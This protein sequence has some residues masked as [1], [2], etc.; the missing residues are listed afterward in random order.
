MNE[1][2][3]APESP[4][5]A[6]RAGLAM[7]SEDRKSEGLAQNLS[8]RDNAT[9]SRLS[10][11][12]RGG[13]VNES[14][15]RAATESLMERL[16]VKATDSDQKVSDLSGGNQQKVALAR[17]LH[18]ESDCL[19]LDEPTR[20]V[21]VGTKSE[22]YRLIGEVAATGTLVVFISSYFQEL[23]KMCD[24]IAVMS[25]GRMSEIRPAKDWTEHQL[26]LVAMGGESEPS[27]SP[28]G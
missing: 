12:H 26:L 2:R 6:I 20:G 25:R 9:L 5:A 27:T 13:L 16:Q 1:Q 19:I 15:R 17:V 11:Y 8:I 4:R 23:L 10:P 7:V 18:Q 24:R 14:K 28:A 22:I 3:I 21:D